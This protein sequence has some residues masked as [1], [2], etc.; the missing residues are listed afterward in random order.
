MF[1][2]VDSPNLSAHPFATRSTLQFRSFLAA[3]CKFF[4][5]I[6]WSRTD[7]CALR[8]PRTLPSSH[9]QMSAAWTARLLAVVVVALGVAIALLQSRLVPFEDR[10]AAIPPNATHID[11]V[12]GYSSAAHWALGGPNTGLYLING[13]RVNYFER[14]LPP[15]TRTVPPVARVLD[16]G[17]GGGIASNALARR[18]FAVTGIDLSPGAIAFAQNMS[19]RE[20]LG[21]LY[22]IGSVYD[23]PFENET[24]SAVVCSDVFE[25][26][27]DLRPA[28]AEAHRVLR[29][30]GVLVSNF[31][32]LMQ[33]ARLAVP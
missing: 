11:N 24:F 15:N 21:A 17:C 7:L 27:T 8:V 32:F 9:R 26:L 29:P 1:M 28:I 14:H 6:M 30:G 31:Q 2:I 5:L 23:L 4:V 20:G 13:A 22:T 16:V 25:H 19:D 33:V 12:G 10:L 18:G 3:S